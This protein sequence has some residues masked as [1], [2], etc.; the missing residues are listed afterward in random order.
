[1]NEFKP[2]YTA[3]ETGMDRF[4]DFDKSVDFIGKKAALAEK[5]NPPARGLCTMIVDAL[6]ADVCGYEPVWKDND[7]IG[8]VTSGG[9]AH[10]C[11]K[12]VAFALIPTEMI[13][14][15][16]EFEI[17]ILGEMRKATIFV[18]TLFDSSALRMRT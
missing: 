15:G 12:S 14:E 3:A 11:Q 5:Q 10:Y 17:E 2:D 9:F 8:F 6:D 1:M 16:N 4:I 18:E 13:N 7:V